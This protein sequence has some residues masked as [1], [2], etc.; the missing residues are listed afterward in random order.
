V[1][2]GTCASLA[3]FTRRRKDAYE[4]LHPEPK[5]GATG[6]GHNQLRQLGEAADRF[7]ADTAVKTGQS[8]RAIKW[9]A[10]PLDPLQ[11]RRNRNLHSPLRMALTEISMFKLWNDLFMLGVEAQQVMWLRA[12][13]IA[14]GGKA[15]DREARRMVS[16]KVTAAGKAGL[17]LATG[18]SVGGVVKGYRRKVRAN[19][20]RLAR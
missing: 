9:K 20:R 2:R 3:L 16:E 10:L 5:N 14:A 18:K 13:K 7:T 17:D 6:G 8:E 4:A 1:D 15:G 12:I 11:G 19:R